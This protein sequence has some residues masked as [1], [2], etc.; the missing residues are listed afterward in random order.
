MPMVKG[1][2]KTSGRIGEAGA[3]SALDQ[4]EELADPI[5]RWT[6]GNTSFFMLVPRRGCNIIL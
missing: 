5:I 6:G 2:R 1:L 4:L 3:A